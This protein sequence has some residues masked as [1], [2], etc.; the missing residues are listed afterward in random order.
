M[1]D[2]RTL[3]PDDEALLA[4]LAD[5]VVE[6]R[7]ES[8]AILALES[9]L[10]MAFIA[11]QSLVFFEPIVQALFRFPDYR[12]FAALVERRVALERLAVLIE[13]R[14]GARSRGRAAAPSRGGGTPRP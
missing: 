11:G 4:R 9:V 2:E 13:T 1:T 10:P 5:R 7:L 8:A 6:L 3:T 14:A 12:R